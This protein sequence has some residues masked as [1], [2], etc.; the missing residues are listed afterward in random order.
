MMSST[1]GPYLVIHHKWMP[2]GGCVPGYCGN[3]T[4]LIGVEEEYPKTPEVGDEH[5]QSI[6]IPVSDIIDEEGIPHGS[7]KVFQQWI[8]GCCSTGV[9]FQ[10]VLTFS[11]DGEEYTH[12]LG[13]VDAYNELYDNPICESDES[14]PVDEFI[15]TKENLVKG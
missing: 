5:W 14:N 13:V 10:I 3:D 6:V 15:L 8:G 7:I 1:K 12:E 4:H 2:E 11:H 9:R